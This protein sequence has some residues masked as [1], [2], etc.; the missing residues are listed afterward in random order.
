[1]LCG[2]HVE[3]A[4][5]LCCPEH[6]SRVLQDSLLCSCCWLRLC[7]QLLCI[8]WTEEAFNAKELGIIVNQKGANSTGIVG[9]G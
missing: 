9:Q 6:S 1:M 2:A 8:A 4:T 5:W 7:D 3:S